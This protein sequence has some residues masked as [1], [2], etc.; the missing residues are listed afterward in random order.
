[1]YLFQQ[2]SFDWAY[3]CPQKSL[4]KLVLREPCWK[5]RKKMDWSGLVGDYW[6]LFACFG[7]EGLLVC[8]AAIHKPTCPNPAD[9]KWCWENI[10][11]CCQATLFTKISLKTVILFGPLEKRMQEKYPFN[12]WIVGWHQ[13]LIDLDFFVVQRESKCCKSFSWSKKRQHTINI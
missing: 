2:L 9:W 12:E 11:N 1:M 10:F 7:H 4:F 13:T 6:G 8:T 3:Q 5:T